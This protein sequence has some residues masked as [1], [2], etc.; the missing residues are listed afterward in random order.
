MVYNN[1][2]VGFV[3][4]LYNA[5]ILI[6]RKQRFGNWISF[7]PQ[8]KGKKSLLGSLISLVQGLTSA[9]SKG[10]NEVCVSS[11]HLKMGTNPVFETLL[12][13]GDE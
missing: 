11:S 9:L 4:F 10:P 7:C 1:Q 5:E 2:N 12:L 6:I 8:V 13:P 3:E